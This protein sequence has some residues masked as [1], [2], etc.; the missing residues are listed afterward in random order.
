MG[1]HFVQGSFIKNRK[2]LFKGDF[3]LLGCTYVLPISRVSEFTSVFDLKLPKGHN[4]FSE[5]RAEEGALR[6]SPPSDNPSIERT[7]LAQS[8]VSSL[9]EQGSAAPVISPPG[10]RLTVRTLTAEG[11]VFLRFSFIHNDGKITI[12]NKSGGSMTVHDGTYATTYRDGVI[13]T[14]GLSAVG[15]LALQVPLPANHVFVLLPHKGT[16]VQFGTIVP[17]YGQAGG[18]VEAY[19]PTGFINQVRPFIL[20]PY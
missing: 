13:I 14:S 11:D 20:P 9:S 12:S 17:S 16:V 8:L 7:A 6:V 18:G 3:L 5:E 1:Y 10:A 19:F 4:M 2:T 15:R